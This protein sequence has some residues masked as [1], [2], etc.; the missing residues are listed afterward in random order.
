MRQTQITTSFPPT[1]WRSIVGVIVGLVAVF[2][3]PTVG[4]HVATVVQ[5]ASVAG[6]SLL[7]AID[8]L[9]T[10]FEAKAAAETRNSVPPSIATNAVPPSIPIN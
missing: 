8:R 6:G 5:A 7:V 3:G 1:N 4:T 2:L 9:A 10:A